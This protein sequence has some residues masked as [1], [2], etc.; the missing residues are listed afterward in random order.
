MST[1]YY[2]PYCEE[3]RTTHAVRQDET[4]TVRNRE[5]TVPVTAEICDICNKQVGSDED[6]QRIL[7]AAYAEY[8]RQTGQSIRPST[9]KSPDASL[10]RRQNSP[11]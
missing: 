9:S 1:E 2:C 5:I 11:K 3:Y 4:Y 6:D 10:T 7:D 8:E